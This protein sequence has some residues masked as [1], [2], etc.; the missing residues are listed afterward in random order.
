ML[1][2]LAV[3][4]REVGKSTFLRCFAGE[5]P[6][7]YVPQGGYVGSVKYLNLTKEVEII[8]ADGVHKRDEASNASIL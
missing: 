4:H 7:G 5:D 8:S 1:R 2:L 3:G 6:I